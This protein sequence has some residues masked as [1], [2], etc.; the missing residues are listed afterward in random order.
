MGNSFIEI[1]GAKEHNLKNVS[2]KVPRNSLSVFTGVSGSGKS[3]L[4][5]DTIFQEGQR[6]FTESLS[7]YARQFLG[8]MEK[9]QVDHIEGLSPTVSIDQRSV[10]RS[11][12][13]TVG[14]ITEVYDFYRVLFARL[15]TP[16]CVKC[17]NVVNSL[18][19]YEIFE[20]IL[21]N[22]KEA[23]IILMAP[24]V[25]HR[26]GEYRK[27]LKDL[28]LSGYQRVRVDGKMYNL[29]ENIELGRYENHTIEVVIDR[30]VVREKDRGRLS[31]AIES[32]LKLG[33]GVMTT[34]I[35]EKLHTFSTVLGCKKA[36]QPS[37]IF[38]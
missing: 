13:S 32:C 5:Y 37:I 34:L 20:S 17:N 36:G 4:V 27:E 14:T 7:A 6:R 38:N 24:V 19:K 23:K 30:L 33:K 11:R 10:S 21:N 1:Q 18:T 16:Y 29:D 35:D 9:P 28:Q 8:Q 22:F 25:R 3:S 2:I 31:E 15:G 26:K 12:R